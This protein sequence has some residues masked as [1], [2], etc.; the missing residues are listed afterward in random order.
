MKAIFR[1]LACVAA[2]SFFVACGPSVTGNPKEDA[3]T[4][5]ELGKE[6]KTEDAQ[7]FAKKV[8]EEYGA[9]SEKYLEFCKEAGLQAAG[10]VQSQ[11]ADYGYGYDE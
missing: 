5:M 10:Y 3:K 7:E 4:F 11:A 8:L 9:T 2:L 1:T 6:G